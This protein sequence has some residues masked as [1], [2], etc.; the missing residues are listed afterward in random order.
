MITNGVSASLF[1]LNFYTVEYHYIKSL[2]SMCNWQ[3]YPSLRTLA[4]FI[5]PPF[6]YAQTPLHIHTMKWVYRGEA[7]SAFNG[8]INFRCTSSHTPAQ[9]VLWYSSF[10]D[11]LVWSPDAGWH[12]T[13]QIKT[14]KEVVTPLRSA[15]S[16]KLAKNV[17]VH[18]LK[19]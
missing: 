13:E 11:I 9:F 8:T 12:K 17:D 10:V 16:E 4:A 15:Y 6:L 14:W 2:P 19:K 18:N 3:C 1:F 7:R 5:V